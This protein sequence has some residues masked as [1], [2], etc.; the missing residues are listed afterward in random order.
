MKRPSPRGKRETE[1]TTNIFD[2]L[3]PVWTKSGA[4]DLGFSEGDDVRIPDRRGSRSF[5]MWQGALVKMTRRT[6]ASGWVIHY[7]TDW[8]RADALPAEYPCQ[9]TEIFPLATRSRKK[10][11]LLLDYSP[12]RV[13]LG[14]INEQ[15]RR[16]SCKVTD[17]WLPRFGF[18]IENAPHATDEITSVACI[19]LDP[20]STARTLL[21]IIEARMMYTKPTKD[22]PIEPLENFASI[23]AEVDE[24]GFGEAASICLQEYLP[25]FMQVVPDSISGGL[26]FAAAHNLGRMFSDH[27][28]KMREYRLEIRK[29]LWIWDRTEILRYIENNTDDHLISL[30]QLGIALI[31]PPRRTGAASVRRL[32]EKLKK[33]GIAI[34]SQPGFPASIR[35]G[36]YRA[37]RKQLQTHGNRKTISY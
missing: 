30:R 3:V 19:H 25:A 23:L 34:E 20:D 27:R 1:V 29:R 16:T 6:P 33:L 18:E 5:R 21:R 10:S 13:Q 31:T 32:R 4:S 11:A 7:S 35:L 9:W 2:D 14:E 17:W 24:D 37:H 12:I 22:S 8:Q 26:M 28:E 36:D 15:T